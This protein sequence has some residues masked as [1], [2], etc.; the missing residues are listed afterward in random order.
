MRTYFTFAIGLALLILVSF[1]VVEAL[2]VPLLV[3]PSEQLERAGLLG[4][5][6]GVALLWA[7]VFIPVPSS[8]IMIANGAMF[9][10]V[11]GTAATLVGAVGGAMIGFLVGRR[12]A[13]LIRRFIS[14]A[15]QR[16]ADAL[17]ARWG[18]LAIIVSRPMPILA[19]TVSVMVGTTA[20][21]W[22]RA[23]AGSFIG[24]LPAA[25]VYAITGAFTTDLGSGFLVLAGVILLAGLTW[26]V[27][28]RL[29]SRFA[30]TADEP[31]TSS[32]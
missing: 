4:G 13:G 16:Q 19:E 11:G 30:G 8:V 18:V 14:P 1:V 29:E 32:T 31:T 21:S 2:D 9:G 28:R 24:V 25:I 10:V 6:I 22:Q 5:V 15:E 7:D 20:I 23:L 3:D 26:L 12:G 17:L 27:A